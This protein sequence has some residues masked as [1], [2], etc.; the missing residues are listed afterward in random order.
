MEGEG[1][2][3]VGGKVKPGTCTRLR[4]GS[5]GRAPVSGDRNPAPS[6]DRLRAPASGDHPTIPD[7]GS[8]APTGNVERLRGIV[9]DLPTLENNFRK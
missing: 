1:G 3:K 5:G 9:P 8:D 4:S 7:R 6:G 2:G